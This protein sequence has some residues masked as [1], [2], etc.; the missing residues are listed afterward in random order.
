M[1]AQL[2]FS[3]QVKVGQK[4]DV[5][6]LPPEESNP[7]VL[8]AGWS[9]DASSLSLGEEPKSWGYGGTGKKSVNSKFE[10]YGC[11]FSTGNVIG[12][13]LEFEPGMMV[14]MAFTVDGKLQG[15][16]YKFPVR[17]IGDAALFPHI[18]TKNLAFE[19]GFNVRLDSVDTFQF[20]EC[21][22]NFRF[23]CVQ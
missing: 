3:C 18:Y 6:H 23:Y 8:R 21:E 7:H 16:A 13:F 17:D 15:N 10:N 2:I 1:F 11:N 12:C 22:W 19:V 20:S 4:L 5:S 9:I 14:R